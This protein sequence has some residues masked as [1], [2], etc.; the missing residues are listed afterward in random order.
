MRVA[1][2]VLLIVGFLGGAYAT[3]LDVEQ[4]NWTLF[5]PAAVVAL[6]G[7]VLARMSARSAATDERVLSGN[8]EELS[9]SLERIV[10]AVEKIRER[11]ASTTTDDLRRVIDDRLREDLRRFADARQSMVHL[12][13]VQAYAD[14]MSAFAAGERFVN[15]AWS[16][17]ADGYGEEA[18]DALSRAQERFSA[19][20]SQLVA[21][22]AGEPASGAAG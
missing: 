14:V 3:A 9:D 16:S 10:A 21:L 22:A 7:L 12:Y 1:G 11:R 13:G 5:V 8:R 20:K 2:Y 4:T 6:V 17:S 15:R 19:A 18:D